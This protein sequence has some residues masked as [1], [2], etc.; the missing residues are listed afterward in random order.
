MNMDAIGIPLPLLLIIINVLLFDKQ[1]KIK[2]QHWDISRG[3]CAAV[4]AC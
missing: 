1:V 3:Y 2:T 4:T